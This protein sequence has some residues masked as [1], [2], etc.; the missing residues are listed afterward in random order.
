MGRDPDARPLPRPVDTQRPMRAANRTAVPQHNPLGQSTHVS[1]NVNGT[2]RSNTTH[3][4]NSSSTNNP[5]SN[6]NATASA[7]NTTLRDAL[8]KHREQQP[9]QTHTHTLRAV[10]AASC[11]APLGFRSPEELA[12]EIRERQRLLAAQAPPKKD[13]LKI[14]GNNSNTTTMNRQQLALPYDDSKPFNPNIVRKQLLANRAK[15]ETQQQPQEKQHEE[16]HRVLDAQPQPQKSRA[17]AQEY[18]KQQIKRRH[19]EMLEQ[20]RQESLQKENI[21]KR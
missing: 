18:I 13:H 12:R 21:K 14:L 11:S 9:T 15:L 10:K 7:L 8:G 4:T 5:N 2:S 3:H 6:S 1:S 19:K 16:K 20:K 17:D